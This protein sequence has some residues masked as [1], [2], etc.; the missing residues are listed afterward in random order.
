MA[1][2]RYRSA[3]ARDL[4]KLLVG[5][6]IVIVLLQAF[7]ATH[8]RVLGPLHWH[9][10]AASAAGVAPLFTHRGDSHHHH[11]GL[12][13]HHHHA[14]DLGL[15]PAGE[16]SVDGSLAESAGAVLAA[17]YSLVLLSVAVWA[18]AQGRH[19]WSAAWCWTAL[20]RTLAPPKRPPRR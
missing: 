2:S 1:T 3:T 20:T 18:D 14:A 10:T 17:M 5:W 19:V 11:E 6:L 8:A 12:A 13:R 9:P 16:S 4:T 15:V 7:A